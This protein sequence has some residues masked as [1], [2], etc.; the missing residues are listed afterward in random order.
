MTNIGKSAIILGIITFI[1]A[2]LLSHVMRITYPEIV[3]QEK[4]KEKRALALVLP[5]YKIGEKKKMNINGKETPYWIGEKEQG[6][7]GKK[8]KVRGIAFITASPGYGEDIK[9]MVGLDRNGTI[10][11]IS[12][13]EQLETPGLGARCIEVAS[14]LTFFGFIFGEKA[15]EE[16]NQTPWFQEQFRGLSITKKIKIL[17]KGDWNPGMRKELLKENAIS[18]ITGATITSRAVVKSLNRGIVVL[19]KIKNTP[20]AKEDNK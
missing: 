8:E 9:S 19:E 17:K 16:E 1:S 7:D 4:E 2:F 11:G 3:R 20:E 6:K 10:L 18:A 13:L 5:G 12:I 15:D 14:K